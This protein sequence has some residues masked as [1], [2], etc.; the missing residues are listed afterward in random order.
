MTET[1]KKNIYTRF[2]QE[3]N[4]FINNAKLITGSD[5]VYLLSNLIKLHVE[6]FNK[7]EKDYRLAIKDF[8]DVYFLISLLENSAE[9][10]LLSKKYFGKTNS[11]NFK[12]F[13][14]EILICLDTLIQNY[15]E[16]IDEIEQ[17]E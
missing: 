12:K 9:M 15:I 4:Y 13:N 7:S 5:R 8:N 6:I 11:P 2:I 16:I 10:Y 14:K 1:I 17:G 3:Q